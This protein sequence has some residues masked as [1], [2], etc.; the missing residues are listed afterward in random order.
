MSVE[1]VIL[2]HITKDIDPSL[3]IEV[4]MKL[5]KGILRMRK[6]SMLTAT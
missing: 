2:E 1:E 5:L 6:I 4:Y 3:R